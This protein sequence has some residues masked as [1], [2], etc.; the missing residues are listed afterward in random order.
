[1]QDENIL[2]D[3]ND[4]ITLIDFGSGAYVS[5]GPFTTFFGTKLWAPPELLDGCCYEG[6]A[7]DMWQLGILLYT[8]IHKENPFYSVEEILACKVNVPD[9]IELNELIQGLLCRDIE[10]RF[11]IKQTLNHAWLQ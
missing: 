5:D 3:S 10:G 1:M 7:Q 9:S 2:I 4:Q 6:K 8:L 11:T